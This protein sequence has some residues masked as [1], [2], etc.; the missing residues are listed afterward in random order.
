MAM[1]KCRECGAAVSSKAQ[2]CP[3]CG[4]K[5]PAGGLSKTMWVVLFFVAIFVAAKMQSIDRE[6][7]PGPEE[8][9]KA[10]LQKTLKPDHNDFVATLDNT[11]DKKGLTHVFWTVSAHYGS[12]YQV[13]I[14]SC[15]MEKTG[16]TWKIAGVSR[17]PVN[18]H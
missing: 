8:L 11:V 5:R 18:V 2:A 17:A 6:I 13:Y 14:W 4:A 9:C 16:D 15:A 12:A 10:G 3:S 7:H 1:A